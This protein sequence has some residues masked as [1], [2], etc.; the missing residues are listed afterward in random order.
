MDC[1]EMLNFKNSL[2]NETTDYLK[3][4]MNKYNKEISSLIYKPESVIKF[5]LIEEEL[6]K[7]GVEINGEIN[8]RTN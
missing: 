1:K 2:K 7:R 6:I 5:A 3:E 8:F 4:Q